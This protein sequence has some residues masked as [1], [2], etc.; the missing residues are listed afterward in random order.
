MIPSVDLVYLVLLL[1]GRFST[2]MGTIWGTKKGKRRQRFVTRRLSGKTSQMF[3]H[4]HLQCSHQ[5]VAFLCDS[6]QQSCHSEWKWNRYW[7]FSS[8]SSPPWPWPHHST[9]QP[10]RPV[11][12]HTSHHLTILITL[13][14]IPGNSTDVQS[15]S[16]TSHSAFLTMTACK[17]QILW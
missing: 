7:N 10:G 17:K 15:P 2:T 13:F 4:L 11:Q 16:S 12:V 3:N 9:V 5:T 6:S 8:E 1:M 14:S